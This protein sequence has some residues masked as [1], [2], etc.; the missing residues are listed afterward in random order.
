MVKLKFRVSS[1]SVLAENKVAILLE[2]L[3]EREATIIRYYEDKTVS[4]VTEAIQ[5]TLQ[6]M[7]PQLRATLQ[8]ILVVTFEKY[9]ELGKPTVGDIIELDVETQR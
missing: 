1:V 3:E 5:R 6:L 7:L 9:E 4:M 8:S 2:D